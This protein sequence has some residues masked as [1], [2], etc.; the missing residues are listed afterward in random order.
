MQ[1]PVHALRRSADRTLVAMVGI[2][3]TILT[4]AALGIGQPVF[5][6]LAFALFVIA[7]VWP[8]QAESA[9]STLKVSFWTSTEDVTLQ[10]S[11]PSGPGALALLFG[12]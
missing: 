9:T 12:T 1:S 10:F 7:I 11:E 8:L 3:T 4:V 2:G 5:A 6:P